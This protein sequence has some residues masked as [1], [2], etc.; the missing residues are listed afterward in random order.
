MKINSWTVIRSFS[1]LALLATLPVAEAVAA[2]PERRT[3]FNPATDGYASIRIPALLTTRRGTLLALAEGR[4]AAADQAA[5]QLI[6]KRSTDG[7]KSWRPLQRILR[8]GNN[9][10]NNPCLVEER[11]TGRILLMIQSYP[12]GGKEFNGKLQPGVVGSLIERNYLIS[13]D[14]DG[15]TWTQPKDVTVTTK[16]V[17]AV[18]IAG[19]PGI[20]IQLQHGPHAGRLIMPL[21]QRVGP[22]WD[23]RAVYS[24]DRGTVWKLGDLAPG[25]RAVNAKGRATSMVN[26]VQM[27]ELQDGSVRMN[28]RRADDQPFRKTAISR[29]GGQT[30]S[31]VEQARELADPACMGSILRYSFAGEGGKSIILYSGPNST[32]RANGTVYLSY[33]EGRSWPVRKVLCQGRFGYSCLTRLPDGRVGI[34]YE[35]GEKKTEEVI[36]F[37][38]FLLTWLQNP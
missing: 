35:T 34:L 8:D 5:N 32:T 3:V 2:A 16:A 15:D 26:E 21:N 22:F 30:W 7:G 9:S 17:E 27:V 29:D 1:I 24:D 20:G 14:D 33:D 28:S 10:F 13:S 6:L 4:N 12:A 23:V 18:T 37:A 19:G 36:A 31:P 25:A 38:S 11:S